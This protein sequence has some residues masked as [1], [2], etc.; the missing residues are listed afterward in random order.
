V[1][2][3]LSVKQALVLASNPNTCKAARKAASSA[4]VEGLSLE[5]RD[6]TELEINQK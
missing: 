4:M 3:P 6:E 5:S 2:T 1:E